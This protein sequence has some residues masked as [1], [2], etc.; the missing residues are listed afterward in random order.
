MTPLNLPVFTHV[1]SAP[2]AQR[3]LCESGLS[4]LATIS[5][6]ISLPSPELGVTWSM[7]W[8]PGSA[9]TVTCSSWENLF[10]SCR[11]LSF[12]PSNLM[13]KSPFFSLLILA[14]FLPYL[15]I[16][17]LT[18]FL[19]TRFSLVAMLR[20]C[21][22]ALIKLQ[23]LWWMH[24]TSLQSSWYLGTPEGWFYCLAPS[25]PLSCQVEKYL[26]DYLNK[27]YCCSLWQWCFGSCQFH[28]KLFFSSSFFLGNFLLF[29]FSHT[30]GSSK[31]NW[32]DV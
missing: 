1:P 32:A 24:C 14:S 12:F 31:I 29:P 27:M 15:S 9:T 19:L 6:A 21:W 30:F 8:P 10:P 20:S 13:H 23:S 3:V 2:T 16:M 22:T 25:L 28:P 17:F 11:V 26:I 5:F 18:F 4:S 7:Y